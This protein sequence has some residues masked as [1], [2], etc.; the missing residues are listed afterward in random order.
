MQ[1]STPPFSNTPDNISLDILGGDTSQNLPTPQRAHRPFYRHPAFIIIAVLV[2]LIA[3][4]LGIR[5]VRR[6]KS[7]SYQTVSVTKG[8]LTLSV[9]ASGNVEAPE[10]DVSPTTQGTITAIDVTIGQ[11]VKSGDTLATLSYT[12]ARGNSQTETLTAPNAGTVVTINGVVNGKPTQSAFIVI[13]DLTATSLTLNVNE[14]DIAGVMQGQAVTFTATAYT[15]LVAPFKGTVE[16]ISADGQNNNNVITYPVTVAI[17]HASLQGASLFP[18][19]TVNASI[20]TAERDQALLV[21]VS[22]VSFA[23]SEADAHVVSAT[24]VTNALHQAQSMLSQVQKTDSQAAHDD[25]TASY[26]LELQGKQLV[27]VPVVLGLSDG[28]NTQVLAGL[29]EGTAVVTG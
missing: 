11:Q 2:V 1:R 24:D 18:Q 21:P 12:D 9:S 17:D 23:Q 29:S 27:V 5:A 13:D 26:V 19:M 20:I 22:A 6:S 16:Y 3:A 10:Y 25:L 28:T 8:T 14:A 15:N 4:L 7:T